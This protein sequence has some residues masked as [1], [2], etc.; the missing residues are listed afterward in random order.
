MF[1]RRVVKLRI[2]R[3]RDGHDNG[4]LFYCI[5]QPLTLSVIKLI[6]TVID[7]LLYKIREICYNHSL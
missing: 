3:G 4:R 6:M 5:G 7:M 2:G 1:R